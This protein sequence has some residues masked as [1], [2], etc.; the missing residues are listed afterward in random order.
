MNKINQLVRINHFTSWVAALSMNA[1]VST[2]HSERRHVALV[3]NLGFPRIGAQRELKFA[4]EAYWRGDSSRDELLGVAA[5]RRRRHWAQ[6]ARLDF[7]P[8]G[9]FSSYD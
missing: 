9:A 4:L 3:H 8:V 6:Q 5:A 1:P 2:L 7:T